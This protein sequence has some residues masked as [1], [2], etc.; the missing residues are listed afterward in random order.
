VKKSFSTTYSVSV[1]NHLQKIFEKYDVKSLPEMKSL[2]NGGKIHQKGG[3]LAI[4]VL[5]NYCEKNDLMDLDEIDAIRRRIKIVSKDSID[6]FIPND[7]DIKKS[8]SYIKDNMEKK[9]LLIYHFMIQ[10]GGRHTEIIDFFKTF[11]EKHLEIEGDICAYSH[12]YLRGKKTSFYL[13]FTK[14]L[15]NEL[16][17]LIGK[18]TK[19][20]MIYLKRKMHRDKEA[21]TICLKYLRKY[22]FT[23]MIKSGITIEV[24]NMING[25]SQKSNVGITHYLN[26]KEIM[27]KEY[28]KVI[29][30]FVKLI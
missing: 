4:R 27:I 29:D 7:E 25:R 18:I 22:C 3:S 15:Y 9:F 20:D 1:I 24:A 8:I 28:Q 12:F 26:Q 5:L 19:K 2:I 30:K 10:T 11:D 17:P 16:K 13:L 6:R 14:Q 21:G 23:S